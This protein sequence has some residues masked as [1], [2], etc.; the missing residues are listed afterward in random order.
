M[1]IDTIEIPVEIISRNGIDKYHW[2]KRGKLRDKYQLLIRNKMTLGKI[3]PVKVG[4][5]CSLVIIGYRKRELDFDNFVGGCKQLIDALSR[6]RFIWDDDMKHLGIPKF[7]Q[8]KCE[9]G[10]EPYT[11]IMRKIKK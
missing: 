9:K 3:K 4:Q 6:E 1:Q 2:S 8:Q 11:L 7:I 10:K 5:V